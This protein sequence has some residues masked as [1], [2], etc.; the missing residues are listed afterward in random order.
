MP[1]TATIVLHAHTGA[2]QLFPAD[3]EWTAETR[4]DGP[5]GSG[6]HKRYFD[7]KGPSAALTL[8]FLGSPFDHYMVIGKAKGYH[9]CA[10]YPVRVSDE[11]PVYLSLMFLAEEATPQFGGATWTKLRQSRRSTADIVARGC[12]DVDDAAARYGEVIEQRPASIACFLN[13]MTALADVRLSSDKCPLDYYWNLAWPAGDFKDPNWIAGLDLIFKPDRLFCYVDQ[14]MLLDLRSATGRCFSRDPTPEP[15][16][17][18][19]FT[20]RYTQTQFDAANLHLSFYGHDTAVFLDANGSQVSCVKIEVDFDYYKDVFGH[21]L[22]ESNPNGKRVTDP[23]EV[24]A[25]RWM[26][27]KRERLPDFDPLYTVEAQNAVAKIA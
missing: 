5:Q 4:E 21:A 19:G 25:M 18:T 14:A 20:E 17:H 26:I 10:L 2:R 8:P 15:W 9:D 22:M 11:A 12:R 23:C 3:M 7:I 6:Q 1:N 27:S 13:I 16:G 24:Y